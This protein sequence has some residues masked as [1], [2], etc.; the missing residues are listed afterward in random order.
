MKANKESNALFRASHLMILVTYSALFCALTGETFL[1]GWEKWAL[2]PIFVGLCFCWYA[3][4]RQLF[5]GRHRLLIYV[6]CMM[7]TMFFYGIHPTSMFDLALTMCVAIILCTT[8]GIKLFVTLCQITYYVTF[9][10]DFFW[11]LRNRPEELDSLVIS[12]IALHVLLILVAGWLARLIIDRWNQVLSHTEEEVEQLTE[13]TGRLNDFLT[14]VSHEVRTPVNAVMGLSAICME[15]TDDA[16]Q[17]ERLQEIQAA[18]ERVTE[19][20]TN[21]LDHSDIDRARLAVTREDYMLSSVLHN[22]VMKLRAYMRPGVELVIDVDPAIPAV[23]NTDVGKLE[24]IFWHLATNALKF[25]KEGGAYMRITAEEHDYGIN[26]LLD[27]HDTGVGMSE[28]EMSR[29]FDGYYQSD[30]GRARATGGLGLGLSIVRGF[31][32]ALG[33]FIRMESRPGEGTHVHVCLPQGVVDN[34]SC[35]SVKNR[36]KLVLGA[37][38]HFDKFPNPA[39][40]EYYNSMVADIVRGLGVQMHRVDNLDDL[41]KLLGN[42]ELTHLFVGP[43]EYESDVA[44]MEELAESVTVTVVADSSFV[45][46]E[47]SRSHVMVKPFYC[48]PVAVVLNR[49]RGE[50]L[51]EKYMY[52][53]GVRALVVDDEPVNLTVARDILRRYGMLVA[54]AASG[55][56]AIDLCAQETFDIVFM[57]HMMPGM[58]GIETMRRIRSDGQGVWKSVPMV[59]LTAN[60]GS[61]ARESFRMAGF[62]G[63]VAKPIDLPELERVMRSVLPKNVISFEDTPR[64]RPKRGTG[65]E[66]AAPAANAAPAKPEDEYAP[67]RAAG[68]DIRQG[69]RYC[70]DDDEFY[71]TL[72]LQ[73]A[74]EA[75]AKRAELDAF[76]ADADLPSYAIRIHALKSTAKMIGAN[77]LSEQARALEEASKGGDAEAVAAGHPAAMAAYDALTDA[78][79][80]A[81]GGAAED[82]EKDAPGSGN[83]PEDADEDVLEFGPEGVDEG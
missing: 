10:Y 79:L 71:R 29:L 17:L 63:F 66:K 57:D 39:V 35:M 43:E 67:L 51:T 49:E 72:L 81:F 45:L 59:A 31:V 27:V 78:I 83:A 44:Y 15:Q 41:R 19:Q 14:N 55:Q 75:G 2:I 1:M 7:L 21:I 60:A 42:I 24:K 25:T 30:S 9:I 52:C 48:F 50:N 64:V 80:T 40:R 33:G 12:R 37:Y 18:G 76:G 70:Q 73:F 77:A 28:E 54:T 11:L 82:A 47:G 8:T 34:T 46:P 6:V 68:V 16:A 74:S 32:D 20:V 69:L 36:E 4:M 26:L 3:H 22:L 13:A 53:R 23:M 56:N 62:D 65:G 61:T 58:D 38:L 5:T